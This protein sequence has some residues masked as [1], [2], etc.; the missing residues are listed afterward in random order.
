VVGYGLDYDGLYRNL[1]SV[2]ALSP[3]VYG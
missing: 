2:G 1:T 3:S